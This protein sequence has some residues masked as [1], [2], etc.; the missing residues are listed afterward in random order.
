[1]PWGNRAA[2]AQVVHTEVGGLYLRLQTVHVRQLRGRRVVVRPR[3][4]GRGDGA[5]STSDPEGRHEAYSQ[6]VIQPKQAPGDVI[7]IYAQRIYTVPR[8]GSAYAYV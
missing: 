6:S 2:V 7:D 4:A 8:S 3:A 5:Y 1:M